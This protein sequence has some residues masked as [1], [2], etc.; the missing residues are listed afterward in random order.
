[1]YI[2]VC[3]RAISKYELNLCL[4]GFD[5]DCNDKKEFTE[6]DLA[7]K[8]TL[9]KTV[10]ELDAQWYDANYWKSQYAKVDEWDEEIMEFNERTG[11]LKEYAD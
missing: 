1:M 9:E 5:H 8:R 2:E 11:L 10:E 4:I 6:K 7:R 3:N